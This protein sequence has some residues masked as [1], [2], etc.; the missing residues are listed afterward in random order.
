MAAA[1]AGGHRNDASARNRGYCFTWN[2]YP[3][4]Y[5]SILDGI[6]CRYIIAGEEVAP[7]TGTPHLQGYVYFENP[8]RASTVRRQ[9]LGAHVVVA[10]GS[11]AENKQYCSKT[12]PIDDVPNGVVY[13]RGVVPL[14]N[15]DKGTMERDRYVRTWDLAK[16]GE[17]ESIDADIRLRLYSSIKRVQRDYMPPGERIGGPCGVWIYG[18]AGAGKSRSV[19]DAFPDAYPKPRNNWWDG[20]QG[21]KVVIVD[22][23]DR[24]DVALGG[25]LKHWADAYPFIGECKGSSLKIR[26][27]RVFVT[28]QYQIEDIWQDQE[29][30]QALMRRFVVVEK[31][32]GQPID[33]VQYAV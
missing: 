2:N 14:S 9:L 3:P 18:S 29:T 17:I 16:T 1:D 19:L 24:F 13:E 7:T 8:R 28:S 22:D 32:E 23:I 26:P 27:K 20:Y 31:I 25:K 10:R 15:S 30:R 11:G 33:L 4:D 5:R 12:R 6:E 21:E